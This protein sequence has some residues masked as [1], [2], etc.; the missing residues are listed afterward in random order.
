MLLTLKELSSKDHFSS[1][2]QL[3]PEGIE[4][5]N[6]DLFSSMGAD[7]L[8]PVLACITSRAVNNEITRRAGSAIVLA[9]CFPVL[10]SST[11]KLPP[12]FKLRFEKKETTATKRRFS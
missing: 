8:M 12:V 3:L 9:I 7:I 5:D 10:F 6:P 2:F 11:I 4:T 1:H